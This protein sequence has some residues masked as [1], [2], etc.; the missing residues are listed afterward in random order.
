MSFLDLSA[1]NLI[2]MAFKQA[3]D[4]QQK[5]ILRCYECHG[6][7]AQLEYSSDL[8]LSLG[9]SVDLLERDS[10]TPEFSSGTQNFSIKPWKISTFKVIQ[11]EN[12]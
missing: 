12:F 11:E 2:I 4:D 5:W 6:E 8:G 10:S 9:N 7:T 1:D 3:E